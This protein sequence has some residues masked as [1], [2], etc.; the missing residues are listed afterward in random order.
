L[1]HAVLEPR[2]RARRA[3]QAT[4][5]WLTLQGF[6]ILATNLRLGALELDIV[7][8]RGGLVVI[9]EVRSRGEGAFE[10][11]FESVSI[12]KRRHLLKASER[13]WR[14]R[15]LS[16][17]SVERVRIDVASVTFVS[18]ETRVEVAQGA[19]VAG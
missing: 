11:A 2:E 3:E 10:S 6:R 7:A 18:G 4:A 17:A 13:L 14:S 9:V 19:I 5:D 15:L 16:D 8:K 12:A 1:P